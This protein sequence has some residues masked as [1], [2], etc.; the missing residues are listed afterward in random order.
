MSI[1]PFEPPTTDD[2]RDPPTIIAAA[3]R[4]VQALIPHSDD[5]LIES[6]TRLRS[7]SRF[8]TFALRSRVVLIPFFLVCGVGGALVTG[9]FIPMIVLFF[10]ILPMFFAT[11]IDNY[12][13]LRRFR[14]SP[15]RNK[16]SL[17]TLSADGAT[18]RLDDQ[19]SKVPW[20]DYGTAHQLP[21]GVLVLD[22]NRST[23]WIP[24][25]LLVDPSDATDLFPLV[26]G[27]LKASA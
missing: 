22:R 3:G 16:S 6:I 13:I 9:N 18:H 12:I 19:T 2:R 4:E 15:Y 20:H 24:F 8:R 10:F 25:R 5:Y 14:S 23:L 7:L 26:K 27:W 11:S 1:N 17:V 21:D